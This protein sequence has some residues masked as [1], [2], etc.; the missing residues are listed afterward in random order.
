MSRPY[1]RSWFVAVL[2]FGLTLPL[3]AQAQVAEPDDSDAIQSSSSTSAAPDSSVDMQG[4]GQQVVSL[5]NR[6]R[7][8][9]GRAELKTNPE[10]ERTAQ[11]Y[12]EYLA[13]TD[14]FSHSADGKRPSQRIR[15]HGYYYCLV[16]ENIAWE[17]NSAG[18]T[19]TALARAFMTGWRHSPGHRKNLLDGDL[20][21]IGVGV[22]R[23]KRTGRYYAV[24]DFGRPRSKAIVFRITNEAGAAIQY[25][26][27][28]QSF[29]IDPNYTV[30]HTRCRSPELDFPNARGKSDAAR[31][32]EEVFYPK[33]DARYV[34]REGGRRSYTVES[35]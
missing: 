1:L 21:E 3:P 25:T 28:G 17:L 24:Q 18:F 2:A 11:E 35:R 34:I 6:F 8:Q 32:D 22:A 5:T 13:R 26:V 9:H 16:A 4:V 10:L 30:T 31:E 33:N 14:T 29:T 15:E 27:D 7:S 12:A 19:T 20:D 23:S